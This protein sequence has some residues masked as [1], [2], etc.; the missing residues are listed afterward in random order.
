VG[1]AD[2]MPAGMHPE[3]REVTMERRAGV[4]ATA[5]VGL[6]FGFSTFIG[7][8]RASRG[9]NMN[10]DLVEMTQHALQVEDVLKTVAYEAYTHDGKIGEA[11]KGD[12][13]IKPETIIP[14]SVSDDNS[15][16]VVKVKTTKGKSVKMYTFAFIF[17]AQ[18]LQTL[19]LYPGGSNADPALFSD[20]LAPAKGYAQAALKSEEVNIKDT[21]VLGQIRPSGWDEEW[22]WVDEKGKTY[23][24]QIAFSTGA[25]G[26]GTIWNIK[27]GR[28]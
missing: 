7:D 1:L 6:A 2:G 19:L 20:V 16:S 9:G 18:G 4:F 27:G 10:Q 26:Q 11:V 25:P 24:M 12:Y 28:K 13:E 14:W 3:V 8:A 17:S 15:V 23:S 21:K 22:L 5:A